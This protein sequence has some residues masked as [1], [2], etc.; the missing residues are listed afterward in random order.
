M[1]RHG[2]ESVDRARVL[3]ALLLQRG[4]SVFV[5]G[6]LKCSLIVASFLDVRHV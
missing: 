4:G 2:G 1:S 6:N 5:N 3:I